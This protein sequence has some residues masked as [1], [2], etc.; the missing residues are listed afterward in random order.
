VVRLRFAG[1]G[2]E[3]GATPSVAVPG[4][5]AARRPPSFAPLLI[6]A[7]STSVFVGTA[8]ATTLFARVGWGATA[9]LRLTLA[10]VVLLALVRPR[11]RGRS[12]RQWAQL[13]LLGAALAVMGT[14][15]YGAVDRVPLGVAA[16]VEFLGPLAVAVATSRRKID[17]V[18]VALALLGVAALAGSVWGG[19]SPAGVALALL[20][21]AG[22]GGYLIA[23]QRVGD[24]AEGLDGLAL[25]V[26]IAAVLVSPFTL[27]SGGAIATPSVLGVGLLVALAGIVVPTALEMEALRRMRAGTVAVLL[28]L[29][30][31]IAAVVGFALLNQR[32]TLAESA[33]A[34]LV[35]LAS[36]GAL[37]GGFARGPTG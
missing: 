20:A 19:G 30:P 24:Q 5:V 29:E 13:G 35:V 9:G 7:A 8:M 6:V 31:A 32:L 26:A 1:A 22:L 21:A 17:L 37:S 18:W 4:G 27:A 36:V 34:V 3:A 23:S 2:G 11:L 12:R 16:T 33:G 15:F 10:A 14:A 28:S 25:S